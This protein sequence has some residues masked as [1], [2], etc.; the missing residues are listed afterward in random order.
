MRYFDVHTHRPREDRKSDQV[1]SVDIREALEGKGYDTES[2]FCM[3]IHP[4]Y[5]DEIVIDEAYDLVEDAVNFQ[6]FMSMG[7]MGL[8]RTIETSIESQKEV[9]TKQIEIA[10][11]HNVYSLMLHCVRA[12]PDIISLVRFSE[13]RGS[14]IFHDYNGNPDITEQMLRHNCYFSYGS[15][16]FN[17]NSGGFKSFTHIPNHL[18]LLETDDMEDHTI[19]EVYER[20]AELLNMPVAKL[21]LIIQENAELAFGKPLPPSTAHR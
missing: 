21:D 5:I 7:E 17:E 1:F 15:K 14:L 19:E 13:Y 2:P 20:A 11:K 3:G 4:W 18:I 9:F 6:N 8:D 10:I 12:Y 16:L